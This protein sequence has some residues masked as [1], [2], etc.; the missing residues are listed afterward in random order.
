MRVVALG[1]ELALVVDGA[2]VATARDPR[3]RTGAMELEVSRGGAVKDM[4]I[5]L[6]E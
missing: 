1:A 5:R 4:A 6:A 2:T 3:L